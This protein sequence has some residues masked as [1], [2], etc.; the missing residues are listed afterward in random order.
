MTEFAAR[1]TSPSVEHPQSAESPLLDAR[2][3]L[4]ADELAERWQ[5]PSSQVYRLAR[6]GVIPCVMLG[7]YRRFRLSSIEAYETAQEATSNV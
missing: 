7:R 5:V 6:E 2:R 4:T 3:L 1:Q